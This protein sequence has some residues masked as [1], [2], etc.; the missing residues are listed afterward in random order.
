M[1]IDG[2][3]SRRNV[4]K[5]SNVSVQSNVFTIENGICIYYIFFKFCFK[6]AVDYSE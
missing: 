4:V 2:V 6:S 3:L 1:C 5:L